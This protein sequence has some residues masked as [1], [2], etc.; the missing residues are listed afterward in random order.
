MAIE[1]IH[2]QHG[3]RIH[4]PLDLK[5]RCGRK[6]IMLP[7]EPEEDAPESMGQSEDTIPHHDALVIAIARALRWKKLLDEGKYPTVAAMARDLGI[8]RWYMA[9]MLRISLLAPDLVEAIV[10]GREP[11]GMSIKKLRKPLSMLWSEQRSVL[12]S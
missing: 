8:S 10:D 5:R 4:V 6:Q 1:L 12:C 3:P 11:D 7:P 9:R 2:T